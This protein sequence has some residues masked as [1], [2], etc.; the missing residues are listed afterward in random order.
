MKLLH[1]QYGWDIINHTWSHGAS[2][3][4]RYQPITLSRSGTT[5]TG[6][7]ASGHGIPLNTLFKGKITLATNADLNGVFAMYATGAATI[8]YTTS[9]SGTIASDTTSYIGTMIDAI[10]NSDTDETRRIARFEIANATNAMRGFGLDRGPGCIIWPNNSFP[11][12]AVAQD[13]C[14]E[15]G[16]VIGR[17]ARRGYTSVSEFGIDNPLHCGSQDMDSGTSSYTRLSGMKA[18]VQGAVDRGE[19]CWIY[20]HYLQ[21]ASEASGSVDLDYPPGQGGNPAPPAGATSGA[22]G[23]WYYEMLEDLIVTTIGPLVQ[24]G[25]ALV[26][27]PSRYARYLGLTR[28]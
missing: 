8:T 27:T 17:G 10:I 2:T 23:W 20:G 13:V 11:D 9:T 26:M 16:I 14:K 12:L 5:V 6:T 18:R 25:Q 22:G 28:G 7:M 24:S 21:L 3:I 19:H 1:E 15:N 4:G